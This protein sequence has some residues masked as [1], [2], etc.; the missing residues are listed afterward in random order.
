MKYNVIALIEMGDCSFIEDYN[1]Q[2]QRKDP[3][4]DEAQDT[5]KRY[6]GLSDDECVTPMYIREGWGTGDYQPT[7]TTG[8]FEL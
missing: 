1:I 5:I 3:I 4:Y 7:T 8:R 2:L 6:E